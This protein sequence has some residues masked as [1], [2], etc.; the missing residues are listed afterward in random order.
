MRS[1]SCNDVLRSHQ[2]HGRSTLR[3]LLRLAQHQW[4]HPG[5]HLPPDNAGSNVLVFD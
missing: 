1:N 4:H 5:Q 2:P 3:H